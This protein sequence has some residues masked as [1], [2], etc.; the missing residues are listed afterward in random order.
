MVVEG[1]YKIANILKGCDIENLH[2]SSW[3]EIIMS[4]QKYKIW[5]NHETYQFY[6][7]FWKLAFYLKLKNTQMGKEKCCENF[8][9]H[10]LPT[11]SNS[12]DFC[13]YC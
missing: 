11:F 7:L 4:I 2:T 5:N 12:K 10:L 3:R 6:W 13:I 9:Q 1:S 8:P